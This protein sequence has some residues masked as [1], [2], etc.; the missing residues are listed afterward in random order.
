MID[1][2][3]HLLL[4]RATPHDLEMLVAFNAGVHARAASSAPN[5]RIAARTREWMTG[6]QP[7]VAG[8]ENFFPKQVSHIWG[9]G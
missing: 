8:T 1:L 2:G 4:R 7:L 9:I 3:H 5:P 6:R